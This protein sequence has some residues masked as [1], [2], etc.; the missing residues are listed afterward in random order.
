MKNI[1]PDRIYIINLHDPIIGNRYCTFL[2]RRVIDCKLE[3]KVVG[4]SF[5]TDYEAKAKIAGI[6][7]EER[8]LRRLKNY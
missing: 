6:E 8:V 5:K 4:K 7:E 3:N 1:N 2:G